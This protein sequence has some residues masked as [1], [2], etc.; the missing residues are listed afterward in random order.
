MCLV[1]VIVTLRTPFDTL[2]IYVFGHISSITA[3]TVPKGMSAVRMAFSFTSGGRL[4]IRTRLVPIPAIAM[5]TI[6]STPL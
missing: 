6:D 3:S 1:S 5:L 2:Y 4:V